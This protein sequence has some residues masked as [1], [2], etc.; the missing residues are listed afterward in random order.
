MKELKEL[1]YE[2]LRFD[3]TE[4]INKISY[5]ILDFLCVQYPQTKIEAPN[6]A[7]RS[8]IPQIDNKGRVKYDIITKCGIVFM[9]KKEKDYTTEI[10]KLI[11]FMIEHT[12]KEY[13]HFY[14]FMK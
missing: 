14:E 9:H 2:S 11:N 6:I 4:R 8:M 13:E 5:E 10:M 3:I 7:L 1:G 12:N